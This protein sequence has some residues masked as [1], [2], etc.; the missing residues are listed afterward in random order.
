MKKGSNTSKNIISTDRGSAA[1]SLHPLQS[2]PFSLIKKTYNNDCSIL[3]AQHLPLNLARTTFVEPFSFNKQ[4]S[5]Y[6]NRLGIVSDINSHPSLFLTNHL[7]SNSV[8]GNPHPPISLEIGNVFSNIKEKNMESKNL[9]PKET[10][11]L[12]LL[13]DEGL[14]ANEIAVR[15]HNSVST[16][17]RH[18]ENIYR[19]FNVCNRYELLSLIIRELKKELAA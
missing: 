4:S 6:I 17:K 5:V 12:N 19:K 13:V 18:I 14:Y 1:I 3:M 15:L 7:S 2:E 10:Q 11:V 16:I 8:G 9:T